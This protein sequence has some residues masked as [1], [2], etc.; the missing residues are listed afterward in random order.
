MLFT[1]VLVQIF[2]VTKWFSQ[3]GHLDVSGGEEIVVGVG[4]V[5]VIVDEFRGAFQEGASQDDAPDGEVDGDDS[6]RWNI[7]L[8]LLLL[9]NSVYYLK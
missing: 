2:L 4:R 3:C 7:L 8:L 5:V 6:R 9:L 1:K